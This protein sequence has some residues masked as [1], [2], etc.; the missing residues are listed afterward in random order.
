LDFFLKGSQKFRARLH[1]NTDSPKETHTSKRYN[2]PLEFRYKSHVFSLIWFYLY[3]WYVYR[4]I[5]CI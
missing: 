2:F 5:C 3:M 4:L 1:K